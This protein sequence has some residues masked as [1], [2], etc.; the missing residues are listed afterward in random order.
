VLYVV[1]TPIGNLE[2]FTF[3]A[4]RI[5]KEVDLIAAEDTRRTAKLLAHYGISKPVVSLREHNES[6][7]TPRLVQ[8]LSA[9][10]HIALVSDAGTPAIADPGARLVRAALASGLTVTPIPGPSAIT[11]ALSVSGFLSSEFV[12]MG[13]PPATGAERRRWFERLSQEPGVVV[14][15]EAPHRIERSLV[16]LKTVLAKRPILIHREITKINE[17]LVNAQK[18]TVAG[19]FTVVVAPLDDSDQPRRS[20]ESG[21]SDADLIGRTIESRLFDDST[22]PRIVAA[23]AGCSEHAAAKIVKKHKIKVKQQKSPAT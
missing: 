12:F 16:D 7:E 19:E 13:F 17:E 8:K 1:A 21:R 18:F 5:L 22:L 20:D 4:L 9:G 15:F 3:R 6:R 11:A 23:L 2:D 10:A 14:F